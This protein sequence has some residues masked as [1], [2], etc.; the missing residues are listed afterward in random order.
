M[1]IK[2]YIT[3]DYQKDLLVRMAYHSSAIENNTVTLSETITIILNQTSPERTV[4]LREIYEIANHK[5]AID[6]VFENSSVALNVQH[7]KD[8]HSVLMDKLN[9]EK[10]KFKS[11]SNAIVGATFSTASAIETP[12]LMK[13]WV[14]NTN[15]RLQM[16]NSNEEKIRIILEAHIQFE[17]IHPFADGNGRT[18]R[19]VMIQQLLQENLIPFVI[20]KENKQ[21]YIACLEN[22]DVE[23]FYQMYLESVE[24]EKQKLYG[25]Y[26][27]SKSEE[28]N[29]EIEK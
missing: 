28:Q 23:G 20:E 11:N 9:H 12:F 5:E 10:G 14:D 2:K 7:I 1:D 29:I 16:T 4:N 24:F 6:L 21:K 13:Q 15:Y 25:L 27:K 17:R 8:I 18:G 22:Q 26:H 19:L 3:S